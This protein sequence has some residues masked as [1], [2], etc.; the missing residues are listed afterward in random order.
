MSGELQP[1]TSVRP[2]VIGEALRISTTPAREALQALRVEGFLELIPRR[3]FQVA[4][5]TGQDIRDLF[6]VQ[7]LI[8]GELAARAAANATEQ[9]IAELA[10][11][12]HELIAAASR[13]DHEKLEE[14]NHAFHREINLM[15]ES[16]K[17]VWALELVTRYVPR[18]FYS[19]I[20]GWPAATVQDHTKLLEGVRA[21]DAGASR[22]AMYEHIT[23]A[24]ELLAEHF[25]RRIAAAAEPATTADDEANTEARKVPKA[26]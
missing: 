16:R 17:T 1:G 25:D 5:L 4:P 12:H 9:D 23:H 13:N 7:A 3:G 10:A 11:L 8:A 26:S 15:A 6:Q 14:K 19:A 22:S 20:E 21:K 24:G 18:R 2:E